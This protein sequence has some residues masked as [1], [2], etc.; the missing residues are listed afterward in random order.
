[1]S[2]LVL[3]ILREVSVLVDVKST[4][5]VK[6]SRACKVHAFTLKI[7]INTQN[8]FYLF[9]F[10]NQ[11]FLALIMFIISQFSN[12]YV[13]TRPRSLLILRCEKPI[14]FI[15]MNKKFIEHHHEYQSL[16]VTMPNWSIKLVCK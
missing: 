1:M 6:A 10:C 11:C 13:V 12:I 16:Q 2:I 4:Y 3:Q 9:C 5:L 7:F 14:W 8:F 15:K